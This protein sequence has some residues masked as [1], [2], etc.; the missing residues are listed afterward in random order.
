MIEIG[1]ARECE[2][3]LA[4]LRAEI[5]SLTYEKSVKAAL[6]GSGYSTELIYEADLENDSENEARRIVLAR[7]RGYGWNSGLFKDFPTDVTWRRVE[8]EPSEFNRFLYIKDKGWIEMSGGTRRPDQLLER[9]RRGE[10]P[11]GFAD[12][13][14]AIQEQLRKGKRYPELIV[15]EGMNGDLILIEG[16]TRTTAYTASELEEDVKLIVASSPS[17]HRWH[18]Y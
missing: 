7:Y 5:D 12:S 8:L 18:Y 9:M 13:I 6:Q 2:M 16:H 10:T 3:V 14:A 17:M 4:F 11:A 15:A 1:P